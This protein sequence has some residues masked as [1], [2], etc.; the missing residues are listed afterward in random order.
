V[1]VVVVAL[2]TVAVVTVAVVTVVA[3]PAATAPT[4]GGAAPGA[5]WAELAR[6]PGCAAEGPAE[7]AW[8]AVAAESASVFGAVLEPVAPL[9]VA[10]SHQGL[11]D[12]GHDIRWL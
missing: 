4:I 8:P 3:V 1:V 9:V 11:L 2:V 10:N 7:A 5:S 12:Q 6:T